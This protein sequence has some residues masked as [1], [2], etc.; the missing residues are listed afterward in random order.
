MRM[1]DASQGVERFQ[2]CPIPE[3]GDLLGEVCTRASSALVPKRSKPLHR[4]WGFRPPE[5][6][7]SSSAMKSK[8]TSQGLATSHG[9][10]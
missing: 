5:S 1:K 4:I 10:R 7:V 8:D 3:E 6:R 9:A 2:Q